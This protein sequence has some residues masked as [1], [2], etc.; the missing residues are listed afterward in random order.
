MRASLPFRLALTA[1]VAAMP[2]GRGAH[3]QIPTVADGSAVGLTRFELQRGLLEIDEQRRRLEVALEPVDSVLR[4]LAIDTARITALRRPATVDQGVTRVASLARQVRLSP[5]SPELAARLVDAVMS[6]TR[7]FSAAGD[8]LLTRVLPGSAGQDALA[9]APNAGVVALSND[10]PPYNTP[11][12]DKIR[13]SDYGKQPL[14]PVTID[15]VAGFRAAVSD[16]GFQVYR[17]SLL[18]A[19]ERRMNDI[20]QGRDAARADIDRLRRRAG[21]LA[22]EIGTEDQNA[23]RAEAHAINVGLPAL[24]VI[25]VALLLVPRVYRSPE[26]Q[27]WF[28]TSG[29]VLE[30]ATLALIIVAVSILALA[31][32]INEAVIGTVLGGVLGYGLGRGRTTAPRAEIVVPTTIPTSGG[33][34][35]M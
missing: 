18:G 4:L 8:V 9:R 11:L 33:H 22:R 17:A 2:I 25:L 14:G 5:D 23:G 13:R 1:L 32:R 24:A 12:W 21:D 20:R 3:A 30:L 10:L 15:D 26:L 27:Q 19:F 28:F 29:L 31:G 35:R 16:T 7:E 6:A 34:R